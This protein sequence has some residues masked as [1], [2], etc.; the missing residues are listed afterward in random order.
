MFHRSQTGME[1]NDA[2]SLIAAIYSEYTRPVTG[3]GKYSGTAVLDPC[4]GVKKT[5]SL[6]G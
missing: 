1:Y 5:I 4:G 6:V 3:L 2:T